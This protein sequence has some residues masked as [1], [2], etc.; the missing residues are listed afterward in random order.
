MTLENDLDQFRESSQLE[1]PYLKH[2][3]LSNPFPNVGEPPTEVLS[4]QK[5][6]KD[7]FF[8]KIKEFGEDTAN[9]TIR[10][11]NGAGKTNILYYFDAFL[12]EA[13]KRKIL[14]KILYSI[15][16]VAQE[17]DY[18]HLHSEIIEKLIDA[19]IGEL[20]EALNK[21]GLLESL[22]DEEKHLGYILKNIQN[23][24]L[25]SLFSEDRLYYF[26][27]WL[28]GHKLSI[29][30]RRVLPAIKDDIANSTL[31]IKYLSAYI[32]ILVKAELCD[33]IVI[34]IDELEH[35]FTNI[36]KAKQSAYASDV[37]HLADT[38]FKNSLLVF[39]I[40]PGN[41]NLGD[42][43]AL[44]RRMGEEVE[45][46]S[47]ENSDEAKEYVEGYLG[48]GRKK[49]SLKSEEPL[50]KEQMCDITPLSIEIINQIFDEMSSN[51]IVI[52]GHF[53]PRIRAAMAEAVEPKE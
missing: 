22:N 13:K 51:E 1:N 28:K 48:F 31:A 3:L 47:I 6:V 2:N 25:F 37:R 17:D 44:V 40:T 43:P 18:T 45:L 11:V 5:I 39:A 8:K 38:L 33:G 36:S 26:K 32:N 41:K 19:T 12:K 16:V 53:L 35:L 14:P 42:Y 4:N 27:K 30:E 49:Y 15:Y 10:G 7:T 29:V 24:D 34:L 20:I 52:P 9:L 23:M 21:K 50:S 46:Q